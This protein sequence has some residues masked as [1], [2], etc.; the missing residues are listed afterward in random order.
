MDSMLLSTLITLR[1]GREW[2]D[3]NV[4]EDVLRNVRSVINLPFGVELTTEDISVRIALLKAR[5]HRF[6][7]LVKTDG[8]QWNVDEHF[9]SAADST[10]KLLFQVL[11]ISQSITSNILF[12][13]LL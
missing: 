13:N 8:V 5:Y 6:K 7:K 2:D 12:K 9:V 3:A 11:I 4:P 10:W 1:S